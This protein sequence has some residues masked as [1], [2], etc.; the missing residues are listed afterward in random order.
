MKKW[1]ERKYQENNKG[2]ER[3]GKREERQEEEEWEVPR[4]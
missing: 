1:E 2:I 4:R 3:E